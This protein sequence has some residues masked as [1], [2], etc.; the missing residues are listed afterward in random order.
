MIF[1]KKLLCDVVDGK[2]MCCC[3]LI[4]WEEFL[5]KINDIYYNII[6]LSN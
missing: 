6:G 2:V 5:L 4:F 1:L 3:I